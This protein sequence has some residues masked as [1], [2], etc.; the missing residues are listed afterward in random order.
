MTTMRQRNEYD[1]R[2]TVLPKRRQRPTWFNIAVEQQISISLVR[3]RAYCTRRK[4]QIQMYNR[5][6]QIVASYYDD[7]II[8]ISIIL[9]CC[10]LTSSND[11]FLF[12]K[13]HMSVR[14]DDTTTTKKQS[15]DHVSPSYLR[16]FR[17]EDEE[18]EEEEE[19]EEEE[20]C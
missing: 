11:Y 18:D 13:G 15:Y 10:L 17:Q 3:S 8:V 2:K 19:E 1:T 20:G 6:I 12:F 4:K 16:A 14:N 7:L 5:D 9:Y